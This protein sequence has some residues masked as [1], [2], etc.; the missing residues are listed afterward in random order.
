MFPNGLRISSLFGL[1]S[2][3]QGFKEQYVAFMKTA[4]Q[5]LIFCENLFSLGLCVASISSPREHN[6]EEN[7]QRL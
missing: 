1:G 5:S 4:K 3:L 2:L 7:S 6:S